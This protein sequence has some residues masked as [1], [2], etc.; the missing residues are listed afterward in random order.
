ML[1]IGAGFIGLEL[2]SVWRRLGAG[3]TVVEFLDRIAP[4]LDGELARSFR[5]L[6]ERQG[7]AFRL[8][9]RVTGIE[10]RDDGLR[11]TLEP[12]A[13]GDGEHL[14]CDVALVAVGRRPATDGL[15]VVE[16]G[17]GTDD[18]GRIEVDGRFATS[19]PGVFAIG[20]CIA[21][22][23]LAHKAE[24][25]GIAVAEIIVGKA[26][27][28]N[29][30]AIP[31]VVYTDPEAAY[32]GRTEEEL[33]EAGVDYAAGRFSMLANSRAR[34]SGHGGGMVKILAERGTDRILGVHILGP[35]A[36]ELIAEAVLAMEFGASAE[37]LARTCHAHPT[38]AEAVREAALAVDGRAIHA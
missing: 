11:A 7:M 1:V 2:G 4:G 25:E 8:A 37:D 31:G 5:K 38:Y 23:M 6:L 21:G 24:D 13:G 16:A 3:V 32:V 33:R 9:T 30:D 34:T 19:V 29:R 28:V 22:P 35:C 26:G 36:G 14:D 10:T 15:G 18:L 12:A 17:I 20:D 27:H